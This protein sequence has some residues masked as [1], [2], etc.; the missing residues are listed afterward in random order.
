MPSSE[1]QGQQPGDRTGGVGSLPGSQ[2][3]EGV[4]VLP[5]EGAIKTNNLVPQE[6]QDELGDLPG[7]PEKS[8]GDSGVGVSGATGP[9][10]R[11]T[12]SRVC[13]HFYL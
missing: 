8:A 13:T 4:A 5:E 9:L 7:E 12:E 10:K 6:D 3:E 1:T 2:D 11:D